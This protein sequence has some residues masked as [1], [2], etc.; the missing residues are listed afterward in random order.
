MFSTVPS[1]RGCDS[2]LAHTLSSFTF[3]S[4][5]PV[6]V[7][8]RSLTVPRKPCL[9][10]DC[11]C[12]P[13]PHPLCRD[14]F[15]DIKRIAKKIQG[16][17]PIVGLVSRLSSPGGGFDE[18]SYPEFCRSAFDAADSGVR[19]AVVEMEKRYGKVKWLMYQWVPPPYWDSSTSLVK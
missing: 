2:P 5:T 14:A 9:L 13:T 1:S 6:G 15:A 18:I 19:N 10:A 3:A 16:A 4:R 11:R 7:D 8:T 17:L 12:L